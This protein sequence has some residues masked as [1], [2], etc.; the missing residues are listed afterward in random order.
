M[1]KVLE[2]NRND[3]RVIEGY[4]RNIDKLKYRL[5]VR[6]L[7]LLDNPVVDNPGGGRSNLPGDPVNKEVT[8]C[9]TDEYY[10]NIEK[11]IKAIEKVYEKSD[12]DVKELFQINYWNP[13][14]H[15]DTWEKKAKYFYTSKTTLLR[16]RER[17]LRDIANEMDYINSDF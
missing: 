2:L 1:N 7:E 3:M 11:T 4:I 13:K 10:R 6:R 5:Q 15:L 8:I 9:L 14:L 16:V 12:D 17:Y